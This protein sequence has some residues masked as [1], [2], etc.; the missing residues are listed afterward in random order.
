MFRPQNRAAAHMGMDAVVHGDL[1]GHQHIVQSLRAM[2]G[3]SKIFPG[4][5]M[6]PVQYQ[7]IGSQTL[8]D[9]AP[10]GQSQGAGR[11]AGKLA[12]RLFYGSARS[13]SR[14]TVIPSYVAGEPHS[15]GRSP[16]DRAAS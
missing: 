1:P 16:S 12:Y 11:I 6:L 4:R 13:V 7:Q 10:V 9:K 8:G 3:I 15:S 14:N 5:E 2:S